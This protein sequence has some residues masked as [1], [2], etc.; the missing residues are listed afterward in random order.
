ML[1][2]IPLIS[3]AA[4]LVPELIGLFGGRRAG[5]VA[6]KVADVVRD[7][8]GTSDPAAAAKAIEED[9]AK[10]TALRVRLA[11]IEQ[12]YVELQMQD[13]K[14][15]REKLLET[16]RTEVEDRKSA[17]GAMTTALDKRDW[18]ARV[19]ALIPAA[20]SA[21]V[22]LGF[23]V[24]TIRLVRTPLQIEPGNEVT[25][26]LLNVLVGALVAGFTAVINFWL[27]SSQGS[28]DK[29]RTV[30]VLQ[31]AQAKQAAE[32]V[33]Q[34]REA[35][36]ANTAATTAAV[37]AA[38]A[39]A[40]QAAPAAAAMPAPARPAP[41]PGVPSRFDLC[42]EVVLN[43]EGGFSDHRE[44]PGGPTMMGITQ[45]TLAA[46]RGEPVT[47]DDV[48]ALTREEACEIYR[49]NY[50]NA[51]K[52]D[53]LPRGIDLMVFDF[54][55]NAGPATSVKMLQRSVGSKPDGAVGDFTLR[56]VRATE[57]RA[58]LEALARARLDFY[59]KL[60]TWETFGRGWEN[61]V[62][63]VRRQALLM[64]AA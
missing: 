59:R 48:R 13:A 36:V 37:A 33:R 51:M 62:N 49:A 54:G 38:T 29:D 5:E 39:A 32:T 58:L 35:S 11:E 6:G 23:F 53:E 28:R 16:L 9:P 50:W 8:T 57:P 22:M 1:P 20:I 55:V 4:G 60:D 41:I 7:V 2:L 42:L 17:R 44:D 64:V 61:R 15:E 27:G 18:A 12:R 21:M 34:V 31:E 46:W 24:F 47:A 43:K 14:D 19:V 40:S 26:T 3:L 25:T 10:A 56:A 30:E 52:C 63:E 45:K